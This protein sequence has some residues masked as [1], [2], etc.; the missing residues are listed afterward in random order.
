M[1]TT[2]ENLTKQEI[3]KKLKE[4]YERLQ[5]EFGF[6]TDDIE[7][8]LSER[9]NSRMGSVQYLYV[10]DGSDIVG[11]KDIKVTMALNSLSQFGWERFEKTFRHEVAHIINALK[12]GRGHDKRFKRICLA[13]GG[14]MNPTMAGYSFS[15]CATQEYLKTETK[16]EYICPKCHLVITRAKRMAQKIL[17]NPRRIC[18]TC[19]TSIILFEERM[20]K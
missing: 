19:G 7:I 13:I 11:I 16:Y 14:S 4:L 10:F 15:E 17:T 20:L 3:T 9:L 2:F 1:T 18:P 6:Y 5:I 12:G 8:V